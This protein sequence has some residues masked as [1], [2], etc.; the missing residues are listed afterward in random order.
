MRTFSWSSVDPSPGTSTCMPH[1]PIGTRQ[2][3]TPG[4]ARS[5][6]PAQTTPT[7]LPAPAGAGRAPAAAVLL[8]LDRARGLRGIGKPLLPLLDGGH[9][10]PGHDVLPRAGS[11]HEL[12]EN[13][14]LELLDGVDDG[15][16]LV[17]A[18]GPGREDP[19]GWKHVD[20][21]RGIADPALP[22]RPSTLLFVQ[23]SSTVGASTRSSG[24]DRSQ[25]DTQRRARDALEGSMPRR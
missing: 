22:H 20:A 25:A 2:Y 6:G 4:P 5:R 1:L 21:Q 14:L 12:E 7:F 24:P 19:A 16:P 18:N 13:A 8:S 17:S 3:R 9:H 10:L 15:S 11:Q 23:G